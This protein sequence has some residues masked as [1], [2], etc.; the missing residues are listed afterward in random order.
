MCNLG[1]GRSSFVHLSLSQKECH[2]L[3]SMFGQQKLSSFPKNVSLAKKWKH[4]YRHPHYTAFLWLWPVKVSVFEW[5]LL[6]I[7]FK[8]SVHI[9]FHGL[10]GYFIVLYFFIHFKLCR[11]K[12]Q[13]EVPK[14]VIWVRRAGHIIQQLV[15]KIYAY[16]QTVF[17][18]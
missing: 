2:R 8:F 1:S 10:T 18:L 6:I 5:P 16:Y 14:L 9:A 11:K 17:I 13:R 7:W 3:I 12:F 15:F 4:L